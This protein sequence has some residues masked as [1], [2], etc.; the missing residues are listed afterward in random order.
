MVS[1]LGSGKLG[2]KSRLRFPMA[3]AI[4][5]RP[6]SGPMGTTSATPLSYQ[7]LVLFL[8]SFLRQATNA[9][10]RKKTFNKR[11][12]NCSVRLRPTLPHPNREPVSRNLYPFCHLSVCFANQ[13]GEA[14]LH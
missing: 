11:T 3:D 1:G 4:V 7:D 6:G 9:V 12:L 2:T 13:S 8:P 14:G 10:Q 5:Q